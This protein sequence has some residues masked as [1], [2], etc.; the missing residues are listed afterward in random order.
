LASVSTTP[1]L[2]GDKSLRSGLIAGLLAYTLWGFLPIIFKLVSHV[3]SVTVVADRTLCSLLLVGII[4]A[5]AGRTAEIRVALADPATLRSMLLSA[6]ILGANWLIYVY[7]IETDQVLETSLGYFIN[8]LANVAMGMLLLGERLNRWQMVSIGIA[9]VAIGIQAIGLA[10]L[11]VIA[12]SIAIT[13]AAYGY[14]RKT[15]KVSSAAGLFV[16]TMLMAPLAAG[17]LIFTFIRD[18]GVGPHGDPATL[19]LLLLT[20]PA[21]AVPLLLF[22]FA[23]QRL[24]LTTIGMLQ[25]IAPSIAFVLA[26]AVFGEHLSPIRLL[27]FALIW[28]SLIVYT[29]DS[30]IRRRAAASA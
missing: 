24:K 16:E 28:L 17:Y 26:I 23:V 30:V 15:A 13:F 22:A 19:G 14:F 10:G 25:Y 18:G 12:L 6:V 5:V 20:G 1:Q 27:S 2:P 9:V 21:T 29:T 11:P 7:A 4:L 8:P 3:P